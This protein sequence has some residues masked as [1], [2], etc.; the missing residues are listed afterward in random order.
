M[1][2]VKS[3]DGFSV[4]IDYAHT[5][6][7]LEN[8]LW[9]LAEMKWK[10]RVITVFGCTGERDTSKRPIMWQVVSRLS[11]VVIVTQDDDYTENTGKIIKDIL[12]G[13]DRKQWE[14]FWIIPD[15]KEAIRTALVMAKKDDIVLLAWKWDEHALIT[16]Q[17]I[18]EWHE[19]TIVEEM[20]EEIE[21][22]TIMK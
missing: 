17:W 5:A 13:I 4:F 19:R 21:D 11:D 1:E 3:K 18:I 6:D 10:G 15:R 2:E 7:A 22:N 8:V 20:L 16:N 12:P 14:D 9:T